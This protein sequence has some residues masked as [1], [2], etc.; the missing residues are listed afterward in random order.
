MSVAAFKRYKAIEE[1]A[2]A[3]ARSTRCIEV[4][5]TIRQID[6]AG[7]P[8]DDR[9]VIEFIAKIGFDHAKTL[10]WRPSWTIGDKKAFSLRDTRRSLEFKL[11]FSVGDN[12]PFSF[13]S[14]HSRFY[15]ERDPFLDVKIYDT[16]PHG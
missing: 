11:A 7:S 6:E 4:V 10:H 14:A 16:L 15:S 3:I 5:L 1:T 2:L 12:A 9:D 8:A 13:V